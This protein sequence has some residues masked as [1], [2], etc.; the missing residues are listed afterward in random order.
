MTRLVFLLLLIFVAGFGC[1]MPRLIVLHDSLNARQHND[2]GVA[3]EARG[4]SDLAVREY[5]RAAELDRK[6]ARPLI[7]LAN[8]FAF[9]RDWTAAEKSLTR[10]LERDPGSSEGMN[11][12]AWVQLR[13]GR[14]QSALAWSQR[15]L[16]LDPEEPN[17]L[18]TLADIQAALGDVDGARR[19]LRRALAL[20]S[21][22]AMAESLRE[23]IARLSADP[24]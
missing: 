24:P 8:V 12:L 6:W 16:A 20:T 19:S 3:Y 21:S 17:Y 1:T 22:P 9:R 14:L 23:K 10:A 11:N 13:S 2:L 4:E 5:E 18:D 15:A 7:N